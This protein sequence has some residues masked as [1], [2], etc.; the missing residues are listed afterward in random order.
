LASLYVRT[1]RELL[2][3][4]PKDGTSALTESVQR[5]LAEGQ[6][7]LGRAVRENL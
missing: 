4:L 1:F 5:A 6:L 3:V 2:S 7:V